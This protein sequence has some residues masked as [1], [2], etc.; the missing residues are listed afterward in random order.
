MVH[1]GALLLSSAFTGPQ[2]GPKDFDI[3]VNLQTPFLYDPGAGNL[4]LD[5]RNFGGGLSTFFDAQLAP[6]DAVSRVFTGYN[7]VGDVNSPTGTA[8]SVG[9]VTQFHF[10]PVPEPS[11]VLLSAILSA[12]LLGWARWAGTRA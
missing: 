1:S 6:G 2:S 8:D 11:G 12:A 3:V 5:V 10:Q 7:G 4:L 9:L